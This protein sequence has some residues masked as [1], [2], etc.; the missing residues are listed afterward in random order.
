MKIIYFSVLFRE[1]HSII[2][3]K[4]IYII[5]FYIVNDQKCITIH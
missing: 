2:I 4:I 1:N 5:L 3:D